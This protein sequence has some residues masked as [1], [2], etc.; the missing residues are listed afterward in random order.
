MPAYSLEV[1]VRY[2]ETV[3]G[4]VAYHACYYPW[5]ELTLEGFLKAC[6]QAAGDISERGYVFTLIDVHTRFFAPAHFG[7][8][9]RI[10]LSVLNVSSVKTTFGF[11]AFRASDGLKVAECEAV[12][13]C[14]DRDLK[15][16]LISK[17][18][19]DIYKL[20]LDECGK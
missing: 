4:G 18:L 17:I 13:A 3:P 1:S 8:A 9:V 16:V 20:L 10:E 15:P 7:D 19:P 2:S 12:Y 5:F 11:K 6:G 14:L